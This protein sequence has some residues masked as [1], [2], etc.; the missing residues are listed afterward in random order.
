MICNGSIEVVVTSLI[1]PRRALYIEDMRNVVPNLRVIKSINGFN[2][3]EVLQALTT[4]NLRFHR[5]CRGHNYW[6]ML[7]SLLTRHYAFSTQTADFQVLLEDD[8][9][10]KAS[11]WPFINSM[12]KAHFCGGPPL[13]GQVCKEGHISIPCF[14]RPP[15]IVQMNRF[16]EAYVTS[17]AGAK[18]LAQKVRQYGVRGCGDQMYNVGEIMNE[19]HV[20][21]KL[22]GP[23]RSLVETNRGDT[24]KTP[25][26]LPNELR[27]LTQMNTM[28]S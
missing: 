8:L 1:T 2:K 16:A 5:L 9:H 20:W 28:H 23:W 10:L 19:S 26:I 12:I 22:G 6:G 21:S 27:S 15:D 17:R 25:R 4:S 14:V 7:A 3:S 24:S 18:I 13:K 11:F